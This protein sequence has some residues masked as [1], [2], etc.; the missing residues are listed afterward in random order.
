MAITRPR[1]VFTMAL[2]FLINTLNFYDRQVV[3]AVGEQVKNDWGLNDRQLSGL[4]TAFILL[5][6]AVGLPLGHWADVGRRRIILGVGVLVW[7]VFTTL[8]G[9]AWDYASLFVCRLGVGVGEASCAP[10]ANSLLGDLF[11]P[12]RRARA[13][14][15]FMLGLPLGLGLSYVLSAYISRAHSWREAL[16]VAGVPGLLLG[17][18]AFWLPEPSRGSSEKHAVGSARREGSAI[19]AILRIP[20]MWWI[21]LSGALLNLNMYALGSFLTSFLMRYHRLEQVNANWISGVVY[22]FG[23]GFGML[24]GGWL[25]DRVAGR[26]VNGRLL[27]ATVGMIVAAPCFWLA[28]QQSRGAYW[29]FAACMLPGCLCLYIYYST[30]YSTI[31]DI[32]EPT[33][34]GTAMA[35]Y[36]F[37]FYLVAAV[38]LYGFGWLSDTFRRQWVE[39]GASELDAR[40]LGLHDA[41]YVIPCL[42]L[43]LILVLFAA[44][45]TVIADYQRLQRWIA[46]TAT[47]GKADAAKLG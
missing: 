4:T 19:L 46:E 23:G 8:S 1:L 34:R 26:R 28:L 43:V 14:A 10:A 30:V 12:H 5:Y 41:M 11:P 27:I 47:A 7:S 36:F 32:V 35:V 15:L 6:A 29:A 13:I 33:M 44:S 31:Q 42:T 24:L 22:G 37:V 40:A 2:L 16:Y 45:R 25:G 20:T 3:G 38:G 39:A 21:I 17:M 9:R 18:L